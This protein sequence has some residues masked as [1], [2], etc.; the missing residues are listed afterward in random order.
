M[1]PQTAAKTIISPSMTYCGRDDPGRFL[2]LTA[3]AQRIGLCAS[4]IKKMVK[5]G[6]FPRATV[7][8]AGRHGWPER[9]VIAWQKS[10]IAA[11]AALS[12]EA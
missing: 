4:T 2:K 5:A 12:N 9:T 1:Q 6:T 3:V 11:T 10:R 8:S 7:I